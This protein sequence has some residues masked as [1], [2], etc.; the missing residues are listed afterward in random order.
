M[1]YGSVGLR[2]WAKTIPCGLMNM[3]AKILTMYCGLC[4]MDLQAL[5]NFFIDLRALFYEFVGLELLFVAYKYVS[6]TL[7]CAL[8]ALCYVICKPVGCSH[9]RVRASAE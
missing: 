9:C 1:F 6:I 2:L 7:N 5:F 8:R 4:L 3:W